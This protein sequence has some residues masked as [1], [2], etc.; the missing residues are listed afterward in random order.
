MKSYSAENL[1]YVHTKR[2]RLQE[3]QKR[4]RDYDDD[5]KKDFRKTIVLGV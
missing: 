4:P 1:K 2:I 5:G 3:N